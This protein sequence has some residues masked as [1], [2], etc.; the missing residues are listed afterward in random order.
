MTY[1]KIS[2]WRETAIIK[3]MVAKSTNI[4][5]VFKEY[6]D[7]SLPPLCACGCKQYVKR[8]EI[9][10]Y[11]WNKYVYHHYDN[12]EDMKEM[13]ERWKERGLEEYRNHFSN[14]GKISHKNQ[15]E[16]NLEEY[17]KK[18][19]RATKAIHT[20]H[21]GFASKNAKMIHK[22]YPDL[23]FRCT[24]G[25]LKNQPYKFM[26]V[27]FN[28]S[29]ERNVAILRFKLLGIIPVVHENCHIKISNKEFDFKQFGFVHEY[30]PYIQP[31]N[32]SMKKEKYYEER[33]KV[34]NNNGHKKLELIVTETIE[35]TKEMYNW[36]VD[37][38]NI[39]IFINEVV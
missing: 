16:E 15:R 38:L 24:M 4:F 26:D 25:K 31:Y 34:M 9:F 3:G 7:D 6:G 12:R 5:L 2:K 28:S 39:N 14:M 22:M 11:S 30:H 19:S 35:E 27:R 37:K 32:K 18:Q 29:Q 13:H 20:K 23:G 1:T 36:L 10:P 8:S 21:P 17:L 33:R